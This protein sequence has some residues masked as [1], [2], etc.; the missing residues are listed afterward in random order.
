[1]R[2]RNPKFKSGWDIPVAFL[3]MAVVIASE[4]TWRRIIIH[5]L[6]IY[7]TYFTMDL[8]TLGA[9]Y[10]PLCLIVYLL[11][12]PNVREKTDYRGL[13]L[14]NMHQ[15]WGVLYAVIGVVISIRVINLLDIYLF[16]GYSW[17]DSYF[18]WFTDTFGFQPYQEAPML[19]EY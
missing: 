1:M 11:L 15:R 2:A 5:H 13:D 7:F 19:A 9:G 6:P 17:F 4:F 14:N 8:V 16:S 10:V 3:L 18:Y 12:R